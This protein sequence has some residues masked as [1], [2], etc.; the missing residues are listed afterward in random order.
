MAYCFDQAIG[1]FGRIISNELEAVDGK[2]DAEIKIKRQA[3]MNKYL[4]AEAGKS[5]FADPAAMIS[6][7]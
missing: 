4:G 7:K 3:I 2:N 5:G 6:R 1:H